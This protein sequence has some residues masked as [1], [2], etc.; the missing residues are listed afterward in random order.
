MFN[1]KKYIILFSTSAALLVI[2]LIVNNF[3]NPMNTSK[4][5][6]DNNYPENIL[7]KDINPDSIKKAYFSGGSFWCVEKDFEKLEGV[8]E[9]ISGYMGG[10]QQNPTYENHADHRESV[11]VIYNSEILSYEN[12]VQ[13]LF[14]HIDPTDPDGSFHDRGN[15][16]TSAIYP[17]TDLEEKIAKTVLAELD[18]NG[19]FPIPI[20]TKIERDAKFWIAEDYHQDYY[21]KNPIR[22]NGYRFASGRDKYIKSIW[23]DREDFELSTSWENFQKPSD[24]ELKN[25]LSEIALSTI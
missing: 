14:R 21:K 22:Y 6:Q 17:M 9:A 7:M 10:E 19:T 12:L 2:F 11:E 23:G 15:A 18:T 8:Q 3:T 13:Y 25:Q 20:A 16:Y 5:K 4:N 1:K 24:S